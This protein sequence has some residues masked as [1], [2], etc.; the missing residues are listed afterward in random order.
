[1]GGTHGVPNYTVGVP[2]AHRS[3]TT[4]GSLWHPGVSPRR[5]SR[6][7]LYVYMIGLYMLVDYMICGMIVIITVCDM[8]VVFVVLAWKTPKGACDSCISDHVREPVAVLI[9][10]YA[11][12]M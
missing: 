12:T 10:L 9:C 11:W 6:A 3:K 8:L 7:S 1:M 2:M 5:V 4:W